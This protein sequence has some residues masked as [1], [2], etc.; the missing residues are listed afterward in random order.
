[1]KKSLFLLLV[2]GV[3]G[4]CFG[5]KNFSQCNDRGIPRGEECACALGYYGDFC[6]ETRKTSFF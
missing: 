6:T 4:L 3:F 5:Q 1:M 2:L